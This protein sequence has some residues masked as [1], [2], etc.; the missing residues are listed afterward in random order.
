MNELTLEQADAI[1]EKFDQVT[2]ASFRVVL[3]HQGDY[4]LAARFLRRPETEL[5]ASDALHL[6]VARNHGAEMLYTLAKGMARAAEGLHIP[7]SDAGVGEG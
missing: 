6:A 7:A 4:D 2:A 1:A 5:R 3:P